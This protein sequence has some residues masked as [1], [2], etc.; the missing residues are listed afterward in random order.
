MPT[1]EV[2]T[3]SGEKQ[4]Y[5]LSADDMVVGRDQFCDIVLRRHTVSR[6]HAR[7]VRAED[8]YYIEDL[9]SLNGTYLNGRRLEGRT[10]IKDQDRIHVYEV[11]TVFHEGTPDAVRAA[12]EDSTDVEPRKLEQEPLPEELAEQGQSSARP[13]QV[14]PRGAEAAADPGSQARFRAALKISVDLEG[15]Q[16]IDEILPKILDSL[17]EMFPQA[18]RGY[19]LIAE[20]AD[21]HLVPR[22]IKHRESESGHSVTF[23]PISRKTALH[24]MS[25]AEAI[26]M[27]EGGPEERADDNSSI[28]EAK[29]LSMICAPLMGP[30]RA[31]LGILYLD[32]TDPK[33]RFR[34]EDLDVLVTVATI[35]GDQLESVG[36]QQLSGDANARQQRLGTAKQVQMQ[37]LP[38]DRPKIKRY[39]FYDYYQAADEVGGDYYGYI[40]LPDG[41]LALTIGD[42][43]GKGVSAAL[44]MAHFCAEVRYCLGVS[45]TPAEAVNQLNQDLSAEMLNYHFV[46]FAVCVLDPAQNRLTIVNAGHLPPIR[47]RGSV[48]E[49]LGSAEGGLPLGCDASHTYQQIEVELNPGDAIVMYTDGISEAMNAKGDVFG[50]KRIREAIIRAPAGVDR[51]GQT[52]LDD[53]RRYVRGRL[54]SDDICVVGFAREE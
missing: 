22:A 46:T 47:R 33:R 49:E 14:E 4:F 41:R 45:P 24:V 28:F 1:L 20:G 15:A 21:G 6:Q 3:E 29:S 53:V 9:S 17:F 13:M 38:Q 7:I 32:T 16:E 19:T 26:L 54:P 37:F 44:L 51:I 34:Q 23:G 48:I 27:D 8:G 5:E 52:L 36:G 40:L 43:A 31:P 25:T 2:N 30:S 12:L 10:L 11:V 35:A 42:V 39:R 50:S 18:V